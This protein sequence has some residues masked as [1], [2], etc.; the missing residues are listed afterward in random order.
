MRLFRSA[1]LMLALL[2]PL[3]G[4]CCD[5]SYIGSPY[6]VDYGNIIVQRD[7]PVGQAISNEIYGTLAHAYTCLATANEGSS[8]GMK[9]GALPYFATYGSRRVYKTN[10]PGVG[11]L[12]VFIKTPKQ[13]RRLIPARVILVGIIMQ[14][15]VGHQTLGIWISMI[16]SQL[17][18]SGRSAI[19]HLVR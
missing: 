17:Y 9:S 19:L 10:L 15:S 5:Y 7:A 16:S 4:F 12:W 3:S 8:A 1:L 6:S 13:A 14:H 2:F 11:F 18:N